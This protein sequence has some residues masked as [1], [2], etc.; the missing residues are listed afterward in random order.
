MTYT[1]TTYTYKSSW[2]KKAQK[3]IFVFYLYVRRLTDKIVL[4]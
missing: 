4:N 1:I 3:A 2:R